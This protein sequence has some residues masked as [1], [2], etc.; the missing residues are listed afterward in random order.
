MGKGPLV[1]QKSK[2]EIKA[3]EDQARAAARHRLA[4][5]KRKF[6]QKMRNSKNLE[7]V[8]IFCSPHK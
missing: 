4:A 3:Q 6:R 7:D 8:E 1:R 2:E 5:A